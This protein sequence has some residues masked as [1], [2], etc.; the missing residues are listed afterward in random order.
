MLEPRAKGV[1]YVENK[2]R[3]SECDVLLT[4]L[5]GCLKHHCRTNIVQ[6]RPHIS[7]KIKKSEHIHVTFG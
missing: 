3:N 2:S 6:K 4:L 7:K 1:V 5:Y